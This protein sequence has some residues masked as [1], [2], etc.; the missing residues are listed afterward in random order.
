MPYS[1]VL[2]GPVCLVHKHLVQFVQSVKPLH[3]VTENSMFS[4]QVVDIIAESDEELTPTATLLA[5][6]GRRHSHRHR[7]SI[8]VLE[9]GKD[10]RWKI[11]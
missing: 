3:D 9:L 11:S 7:T 10:F 1:Y 6:Q 4:V 2:K 5:V 8:G